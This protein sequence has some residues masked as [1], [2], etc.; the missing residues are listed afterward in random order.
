MCTHIIYHLVIALKLF[1]YPIAHCTQ[2][3][4]VTNYS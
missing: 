1:F 3:I 2:C 4:N